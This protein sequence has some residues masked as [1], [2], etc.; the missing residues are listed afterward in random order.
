MA[1]QLWAYSND[2]GWYAVN[3]EECQYNR[4]QVDTL[5]ALVEADTKHEL[6]GTPRL[7]SNGHGA[8]T[9]ARGHGCRVWASS[10]PREH[11]MTQ[12]WGAS[13]EI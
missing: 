13:K 2:F 7:L 5:P 11:P 4:A 6:V 8:I 12:A 10:W 1:R 9:A 3:P